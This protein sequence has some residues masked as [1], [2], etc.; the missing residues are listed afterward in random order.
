MTTA[1]YPSLS[2]SSANAPRAHRLF[3]LALAAVTLI[4]AMQ[5]AVFE[6]HHFDVT[7]FTMMGERVLA[8]ERLFVDVYDTNPP[9]SVALY[10]PFVML[11]N[12][13][14][15]DAHIWISM[16]YFGLLAISLAV[17]VQ[18]MRDYLGLGVNQ[19]RVIVV[20]LAAVFVWV[21]P[22]T[23]AQREHFGITAALPWFFLIAARIKSDKRLPFWLSIAIGAMAAILL[24]TKPYYALGLG[25]PLLYLAWHKRSWRAPFQPEAFTLAFFG[26]AY[27]LILVMAFPSFFDF[28]PLI[29]DV[30]TPHRRSL[31]GMLMVVAYC[32]LPIVIV[33]LLI[34]PK[35]RKFDPMVIVF[36]IGFVGFAISFMAY[37]KFFHY[38]LWPPLICAYAAFILQLSLEASHPKQ[39][40]RCGA[41]IAVAVFVQAGVN[42]HSGAKEQFQP[43]PPASVLALAPSPKIAVV[44]ASMRATV[45]LAHALDAT[46]TEKLPSDF[47]GNLAYRLLDRATPAHKARL[48]KHIQDLLDRKVA[49][50]SQTDLD[51]IIVDTRESDWM[52]LVVVDGR[53]PAILDSYTFFASADRMEYYVPRGAVS[54]SHP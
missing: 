5:A 14:G 2:P 1:N 7:W 4:G 26:I 11:Q 38:L 25:L 51:L 3:W 39:H 52:D 45:P 9:F 36:L 41:L 44:S 12:I 33:T 54:K 20:A 22:T 32:L 8:G 50:L 15:L 17:S 43:E 18:L 53:I 10:L 47:I 40:L 19:R 35:Q 30:Y 49:Y 29:V 13:T 48:E 28:V 24:L 31:L 6:P 46:W 16:G 27:A 37:G 42:T 23:F 34:N 21:M